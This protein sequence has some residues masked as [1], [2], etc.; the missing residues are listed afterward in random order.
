MIPL[1]PQSYIHGGAWRDPTQSS[2]DFLPTLHL[3]LNHP[4]FSRA[5][6]HIAGFASL[7]YR[8]SAPDPSGG[9]PVA[10]PAHVDDVMQA[11]LK[12]NQRYGVGNPTGHDYLLVGHSCGGT[13]AFQLVGDPLLRAGLAF[14]D[15]LRRPVAVVSLSGLHDLPLLAR[16][17]ASQ[18]VYGEF[19]TGAFGGD[20]AAWEAASPVN[21]A[22]GEEEWVVEG[23]GRVIVL[24][25]SGEDG[26]VEEEQKSVMGAWLQSRWGFELV[27]PAQSPGVTPRNRLLEL[28]VTESHDGMWQ[29]GDAVAQAVDAVLKQLYSDC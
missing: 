22:F 7:N 11:L 23:G 28:E 9:S 8:L 1:I 6:S 2:A 25:W 15:R 24:V 19:L 20:G 3:L 13:L 17:H 12:L 29:K 21:G 10:H 14:P 4:S 26:L 5:S 18:P 27:N 16:N